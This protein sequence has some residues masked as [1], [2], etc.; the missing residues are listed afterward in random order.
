MFP[1]ALPVA[2]AAAA[3]AAAWAVAW[4]DTG[5][6]QTWPRCCTDNSNDDGDPDAE[7]AFP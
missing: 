4:E 6:R 7:A 5:I 2:A 3:A 1:G